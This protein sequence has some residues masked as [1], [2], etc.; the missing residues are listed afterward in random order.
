VL[1]GSGD[2]PADWLRAGEALSTLWLAATEHGAGLLPL[3][4]PVEVPFTRHQLRHLLGDLGFPYLALRLGTYDATHAGP[5]RTPR[6]PT[7]QVVETSA[8]WCS[9]R[10]RGRRSGADTIVASCRRMPSGS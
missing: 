6:L 7:E 2:E 10:S 4:S 9:W 5:A 3:S 1:Y 8:G